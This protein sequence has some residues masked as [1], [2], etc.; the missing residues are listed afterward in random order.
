M[1]LTNGDHAP[2]EELTSPLASPYYLLSSW[3]TS[4]AS[5]G[6]RKQQ[7]RGNDGKKRP[8]QKHRQAESIRSETAMFRRPQMEHTISI[9]N[10]INH[11]RV[12][13]HLLGS[14]RGQ[15]VCLEDTKHKSSWHQWGLHRYESDVFCLNVTLTLITIYYILNSYQSTTILQWCDNSIWWI[16][17]V[18]II[19]YYSSKIISLKNWSRWKGPCGVSLIIMDGPKKYL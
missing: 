9:S 8:P 7:M 14:P 12:M 11:K 3:K 2:T 18:F 5:M 13:Y 19:L 6:P 16:N 15:L 10:T 17:A 4:P 1:G